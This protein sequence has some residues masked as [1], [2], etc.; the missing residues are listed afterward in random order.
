VVK[1]P[2]KRRKKVTCKESAN[3]LNVG[4]N[5]V[6]KKCKADTNFSNKDNLTSAHKK[7]K[8][9]KLFTHRKGCG[10]G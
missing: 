4:K 1:S 8:V 5:I 6:L 9:A 10:R 3:I 7:S 2:I